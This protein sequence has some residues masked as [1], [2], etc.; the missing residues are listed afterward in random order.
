M[1]MAR[2]DTFPGQLRRKRDLPFTVRRHQY[3]IP[4]R[5][6]NGEKVNVSAN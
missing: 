6:L 2:P 5:R 4:H 1:D 3:A